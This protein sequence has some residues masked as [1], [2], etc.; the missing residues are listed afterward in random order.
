[1]PRGNNLIGALAGSPQNFRTIRSVALEEAA[2]LLIYPAPL[3]R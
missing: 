1:M 3:L 2:N